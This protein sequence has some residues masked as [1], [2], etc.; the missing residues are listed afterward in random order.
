MKLIVKNICYKNNSK[1]IF[2][3]LTICYYHVDQLLFFGWGE[4]GGVE[5]WHTH[6]GAELQ[7]ITL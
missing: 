2:P 4:G 3:H 5:R 1:G 6:I 7:S